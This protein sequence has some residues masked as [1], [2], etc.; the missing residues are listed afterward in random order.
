MDETY[1]LGVSDKALLVLL[2]LL[3]SLP[4]PFF[5]LPFHFLF[6][7]LLLHG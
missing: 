5:S 3:L 2:F 6:T 7:S 1:H 4:F